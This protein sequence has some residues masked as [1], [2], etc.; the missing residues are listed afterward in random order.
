MTIRD[1]TYLHSEA[2]LRN[3]E[4][5]PWYTLYK[6]G[7]DEAFILTTSLSR[8]SFE[9]LLVSFKKFYITKSGY[10]RP[11]RPQ[12]VQDKHC[13]LVLLL[14]RFCSPAENKTWSELFAVTP[15]TL[16]R[17]LNNAED[18]LLLTLENL[19][20]AKIEWPTLSEQIDMA[21]KVETK[22]PIVKGRW[23]FIDGK[24]YK[25]QEPTNAEKQNA[26]YNGWLHSV[27]ITGVVCFAANG[28][29]IWAKINVYGSWN[30]GI[31]LY[32]SMYMYFY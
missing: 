26:M 8:V 19:T 21:I 14:H 13:V 32:I 17:I 24:N 10:G 3:V 25:V 20:E 15:T 28:L 31:Y 29:I 5:C 1:R 27:L 4:D 22:E 12:R 7:N 2:L 6:N 11:G 16:S 9:F 23:G 30:D 18:A